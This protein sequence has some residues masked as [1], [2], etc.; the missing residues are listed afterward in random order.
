MGSAVLVE[1]V[2]RRLLLWTCARVGLNGTAALVEL[3]AGLVPR[4]CLLPEDIDSGRDERDVA[5]LA[6]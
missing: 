6:P 5:R 2:A 1:I 4:L 3:L